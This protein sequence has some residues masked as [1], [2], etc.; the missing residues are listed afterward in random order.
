MAKKQSSKKPSKKSAKAPT[1][2]STAPATRAEAKPKK[3]RTRDPRLPAAGTTMVRSYKGKDHRVKVL[4]DGFEHEGKPY[5]SL[6]ALAQAITGYAAIS[7]PAFFRLAG[8]VPTAKK[9]AKA[10]EKP[11]AAKDGAAQA[12]PD[13]ATPTA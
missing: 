11:V 7:G 3:V 5:R 1:V 2:D 8:T 10:K 6:T 13:A 9:V 4:A 12:T